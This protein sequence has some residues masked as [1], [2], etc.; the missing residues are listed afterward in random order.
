MGKRATVPEGSNP[1]DEDARARM[2]ADLL[3]KQYEKE[4]ARENRRD[5]FSRS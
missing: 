5:F 2:E 4:R 1:T 3:R